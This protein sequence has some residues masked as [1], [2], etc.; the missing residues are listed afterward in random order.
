MV[1]LV[2]RPY[3]QVWRSICTSESLRTSTRVSSGFVLLRHSWHRIGQFY[4]VK[5]MIRG[6]GD[7]TT[8][9]TKL[10]YVG[11]TKSHNMYTPRFMYLRN[12][13]YHTVTF[14]P[15][16]IPYMNLGVYILWLFVLPTYGTWIKVY[17]YIVTFCPT[18]IHVK[19]KYKLWLFVLWLSIRLPPVHPALLHNFGCCYII[20]MR[21][22]KKS[23]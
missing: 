19:Q 21:H 4:P 18:Y 17:I 1:R 7:E 13:I 9:N 3:T 11:R 20:L 8:S 5:R 23:R 15:T 12:N 6:L 14:C 2:F 22:K 10:P 16:Y